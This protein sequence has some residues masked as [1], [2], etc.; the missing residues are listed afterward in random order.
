MKTQ[1]S[2]A[3]MQNLT[4]TFLFYYSE[5]FCSYYFSVLLNDLFF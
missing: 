3:C 1:G 2:T 5:Y 4:N